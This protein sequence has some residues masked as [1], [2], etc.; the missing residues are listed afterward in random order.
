MATIKSFVRRHT[1]WV[2]FLAVIVP[3]LIILGLQYSSLVKLEKTSPVADRV[4]LKNYLHAVASEVQ[5]FYFLQA[6]MALNLHWRKL[7]ADPPEEV[8]CHFKEQEVKGV[9]LMFAAAFPRNGETQLF[10]YDPARR[11]QEVRL[12]PWSPE[13]KAI[14]ASYAYWKLMS[15]E[16]TVI[17]KRKASV[18]EKDPENRVMLYPVLDDKSRT[19][20]V[21]GM[22]LDLSY[23]RNNFLPAVIQR[24]LPEFLRD[25][26][27]DNYIVTVHTAHGEEKRLVWATQPVQGQNE[28]VYYMLPY[29]FR[30]WRLGI[31]SRDLTTEQWAR[32]YFAINLSLSVLMTLVMLGGIVLALRTAS[33]QMRLSQMKT[34]FVSNVSHELRTP[35]SSI[36]VFGEFLRLGRVKDSEK[37]C[38]YGEYIETES[39]RLTQL[40]NN[41]LDFSKIESGQKTYQFE[42]ADVA[43]VVAATLKTFEVR[44]KQH[45]F[46][47][48]LDAPPKPLPPALFDP[49]ALSQALLNLLDNAIKYSGS[50]KEIRVRL[51]EENGF[52]TI[53]VVD[54]GIGI[55]RQEQE[56]IFERF[57][58]VSTGL[59][60]D[61]KGSGLGL[62]IVKHI[63]EAHQGRVTVESQLNK[64]STFTIHLPHCGAS[65]STKPQTQAPLTEEPP[66]LGAEI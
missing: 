26:A 54:Y 2:G 65:A 61:V 28:E 62:S 48:D 37:I 36:R 5:E 31:R 24:H 30:E 16:G 44:L 19:I 4:V 15:R 23:F 25:H 43:E 50:A 21:A 57:H 12:D 59:V 13:M 58:R 32:R 35:L 6:E 9:K 66:P 46:T 45:G 55:P 18:D 49:D 38:E 39:R 3:L 17:E 22:L 27:Q 1:L 41:I 64:G 11:T 42:R 40:I 8:T 52:I 56:K 51:G 34:D 47:V 63:V 14:N 7:L 10:L 60:H 29:V 20:G 53:S 33:R